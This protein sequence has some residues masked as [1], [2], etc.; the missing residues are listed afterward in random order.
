MSLRTRYVQS[1]SMWVP[2]H[3]ARP[4]GLGDVVSR[5]LSAVGI[6]QT[7]TCGCPPRQRWLNRAVPFRR[8]SRYV[9]YGRG[10][11]LRGDVP[12]IAGGSSC[13]PGTDCYCDRVRG[14]D[15]DDPSVLYCEDFEAPTLRLDQGFGNGAPYYGPP[16]DHSQ[17][18]MRGDNF[19]W[20][21][22]YGQGG[23][24]NYWSPNQ[25]DPAT[26]GIPCNQGGGCWTYK[27]W[28]PSDLW[29]GNSGARLFFPTD[30]TFDAEVAGIQPPTGKA[31]G[32]AGAFDGT[33]SL[34]HR[35][36]IDD[37]SNGHGNVY[38]GTPGSGSPTTS[39]GVLQ[40]ELGITMALA[41]PNNLFTSGVLRSGT[42]W[43][44]N[45]FFPGDAPIL[46]MGCG[47]C[48]G[49]DHFP[50]RGSVF[51]SSA[52]NAA[53]TP[54]LAAAT[55][56][57]GIFACDGDGN[58]TWQ[59]APTPYQHP[60]DFPL[61]TWGCIQGHYRNIGLINMEWDI[62]FTGAAG[63]QKQVISIRNFDARSFQ[64][65]NGISGFFF[66]TYANTNNS[67]DQPPGYTPTTEVTYRYEDNT[68]MRAGAP[69]S[70]AQIG[71]AGGGAPPP[72]LQTPRGGRRAAGYGLR[73]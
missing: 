60:V 66:N 32:G 68:H 33:A 37:T 51:A 57:I 53:C 25:P 61:G 17:S 48:N 4:R 1:G 49:F 72:I 73:V 44:H 64:W 69:V 63:V 35:I 56:K 50:F 6:K 14:G 7:P 67:E 24:G 27:V 39:P 26:V 70:C 18:G 55:D 46:V 52:P 62:W 41:Y 9:P 28:H 71:F 8:P 10:R 31:G 11:R 30:T 65:V 45:E 29:Q 3:H 23:P 22:V 12:L 58:L 47:I 42:M 20:F 59:A 13:T 40:R 15:L 2:E 36:G 16:Y 19:Y 5:A 54:A 38:F 34:A 21:R 43:K